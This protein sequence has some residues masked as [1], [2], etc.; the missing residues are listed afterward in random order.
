MPEIPNV[1]VNEDI[2]TDW[3][4]DI[5]DRTIQRYTDK[6]ERAALHPSPQTGDLSFIENTGDIDFYFAGAWRHLG[7]PVG[8]VKMLAGG[9]APTGWLVCNGAAV[10]RTTYADLFAQIGITW[11]DGDGSST[12]NLPDMR[13]KVPRGVAASGAGNAVGELVGSDSHTHAGGS[14]AHTGPSH[15]HGY[16]DSTATAGGHNHD[17]EPGF[18]KWATQ[19]T[20]TQFFRKSTP[21]WTINRNTGE[22]LNLLPNT[23]TATT[24]SG[25]ALGGDTG[26]GGG[27]AHAISGPTLASGTGNTGA[28]GT[29]QTGAGSTIQAGAALTFIIKS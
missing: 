8:T 21:D 1:I 25:T 22:N 20:E 13:G 16:S 5:R 27:H 10:S 17:L 24:N 15:T 18:A 11:G 19:P 29:A 6:T 14:H 28:S 9:A 23:V 12:F 4:N 7:S 3:G 26:S 2:E